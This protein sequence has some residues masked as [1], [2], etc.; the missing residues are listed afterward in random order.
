MGMFFSI[1]TTG[2]REIFGQ[3]PTLVLVRSSEFSLSSDGGLLVSFPCAVPPVI[4]SSAEG[5]WPQHCFLVAPM[6]TKA[7]G[8][9]AA[10]MS[11]F[12][13]KPCFVPF[14]SQGF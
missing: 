7:A 11:E 13:G 1:R 5:S 14:G 8:K 2:F 9:V 12:R 6:S 3:A 4:G 10:R